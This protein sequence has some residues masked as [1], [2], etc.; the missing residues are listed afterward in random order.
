MNPP[1]PLK[2]LL[3]L[4][5]LLLLPACSIDHLQSHRIDWPDHMATA[6]QQRPRDRT[7][8]DPPVFIS[9]NRFDLPEIRADAE[10]L[11]LSLEQAVVLTLRNHPGLAAQQ[12]APAIAGTFQTIEESR[13]DPTLFAE[14]QWQREQ[15]TE[16]S[17]ATG[18]TFD[19]TSQ[20]S[21]GLVGLSQQLATGTDFELTVGT[22]RSASNRSP[23]LNE[24]RLGL[25]LNQ[26]LLR[27]A[28]PA[29][30]LA[31]VQQ[32]RL[33]RLATDYELRAYTEALV[34]EV[35][36]T[37][38]RLVLANQEIRIFEESLEVARK[39]ARQTADRI[40]IGVL[41]END[42]A[43][44]DAETAARAQDLIDAR[45]R[46][47]RLQLTLLRLMRPGEPVPWGLRL[48]TAEP[49]EPVT[50]PDFFIDEHIELAR[51]NR[52]ELNE[53]RIRLDQNRLE[54]VRTRNG[55]LP[56]LDFF[57]RLGKTGFADSFADSVGNLDRNTYDLAAGLRFEYPWGHR[58][59]EALHERAVLTRMQGVES[60]R[61]L[62]DLVELEVRQT[63]IEVARAFA[64]ID[65]G[66]ATR[67]L[68]EQAF[69][70]ETQRLEVGTSTALQV[71]QAQRDLL[72]GQLAE[73]EAAINAR[74][75]LIDLYRLDGTLLKRRGI[76]APGNYARLAADHPDNTR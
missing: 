7:S 74:L 45:S 44:A 20:G 17:R 11:T 76:T 60:L 75:A 49:E 22:Q 69:I 34:A 71:A 73:A 46:R 9:E 53:A 47:D 68:R 15:R 26:A 12:L 62:G 29:A 56:R 59:A 21:S 72:A 4:T 23:D 10:S 66:A 32:A 2:P 41:P 63:F 52:P 35:E 28:D 51:L 14:V 33:E 24:T 6:D 67:R 27:G 8:D 54:V 39:L 1:R 3:L 65:A 5:A 18:Q 37:Y 48:Q 55:L 64:Q 13:F 57:I 36:Q 38:W 50:I 58:E 25:S 40:E 16:T 70:A 43:A 61:N 30:N 19:A 31:S 42:Q